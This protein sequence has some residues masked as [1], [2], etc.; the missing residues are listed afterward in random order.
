MFDGSPIDWIRFCDIKSKENL[1]QP[2]ELPNPN[3]FLP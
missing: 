1:H 2:Q 3:L